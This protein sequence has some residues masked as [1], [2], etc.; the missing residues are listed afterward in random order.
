MNNYSISK[1]HTEYILILM[2]NIDEV[3]VEENIDLEKLYNKTDIY[4]IQIYGAEIYDDKTQSY[5]SIPPQAK[6]ITVQHMHAYTLQYQQ[7]KSKI[8]N[9]WDLVIIFITFNCSYGLYYNKMPADM[10]NEIFNIIQNYG[11]VYPSDE[12]KMIYQQKSREEILQI[13][14]GFNPLKKT[15]NQAIIALD[16]IIK[17]YFLTLIA[18]SDLSLLMK[19]THYM[20]VVIQQI[21]YVSGMNYLNILL[22]VRNCECKHIFSPEDN[23]NIDVIKRD[24][25]HLKLNAKCFVNIVM[26]VYKIICSFKKE[27]KKDDIELDIGTLTIMSNEIIEL[28]DAQYNITLD[29]TQVLKPIKEITADIHDILYKH[30]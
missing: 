21:E 12:L 8:I 18:T 16:N 29:E 4:D 24:V 10:I 2:N 5:I 28:I 11:I 20:L 22:Q 3:N 26:T 1:V 23:A 13:L 14:D 15:V 25:E 27:L 9:V 7:I 19:I 17:I 6:C 30:I